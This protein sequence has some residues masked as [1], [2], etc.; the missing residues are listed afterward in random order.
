MTHDDVKR[1]TRFTEEE[2]REAIRCPA[3]DKDVE[4]LQWAASEYLKAREV[5]A[6][7]GDKMKYQE[8][9]DPTCDCGFCY[10]PSDTVKDQG[11]RARDFLGVKS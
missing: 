6:W 7:Y 1:V 11:Q 9:P 8:K 5:L 3:H 10:E 4:A 2:V